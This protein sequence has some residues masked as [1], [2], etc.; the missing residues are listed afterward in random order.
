[1]R[2]K[3]KEESVV[4]T[5]SFRVAFKRTLPLQVM[6]WIPLGIFC[7]FSYIPIYGIS[8]AFQDF[9]LRQ[10]FFGSP[11]VGFE[12]FQNILTDPT[13]YTLLKNNI[14]LGMLGIFTAQP[15]AV[16]LALIINE[17]RIEK[18]KNAV[19]IITCLPNFLSVVTVVG[20]MTL[21]FS[22]TSGVVNQ[23]L[24]AMG[25]EP[26][27]FMGT[28]SWYRPMFIGSNIWAHTGFGAIYYLAALSSIDVGLYEAA[29]LDGAS[30]LQR[31]WYINL[32]YVVPT[33]AMLFIL[34][35]GG[36]LNVDTSKAI[37][38]YSPLNSS[39]SDIVGT[40]TYRRGLLMMEYSYGSAIGLLMSLVNF[41][42]L[43][44]FN[45]LSRKTVKQSI[46]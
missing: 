36:V 42:S 30:R 1:M 3:K 43:V 35:M 33:F 27:Y 29:A 41:V 44:F 14:I 6:V 45:W 19:Q 25:I 5:L 32:P 31:I 28:A 38:M 11:W 24:Q 9:S 15:C 46:W 21:L 20:M 8:M 13:I 7:I 12:H 40:Y 4:S 39:V 18:L 23:M 26:I 22:P 2:K 17:V 10:G 16:L 34:G 37:L